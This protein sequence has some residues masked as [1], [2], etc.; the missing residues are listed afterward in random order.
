MQRCL[1]LALKGL[2]NVSSNPMVG[3]VI[4]HDNKIIGEGFHQKYG[5][6]HAEVNAI[7]SVKNKSLLSKSTLYVNLEPCSHFGKTPPCCNLII[8]KK[9]PNV[10]IGCLDTFSKVSGKGA[11][12]MKDANIKVDIGCLENKCR[13]LNK[14]FFTFHEKNRPY[15]ILKWAE[16]KDGYIAPNNQNKPFWMTSNKSKKLVH[17]WRTEED[18]ILVGRAT[19]EKDNPLL[20]SRE[21]KGNNPIRIVIDKSLK[22]SQNHNIFNSESKTIIF[23]EILSSDK[24]TNNY[25]KINFKKII[26]N[27]LEQ[28][29]SKNIQSVIIEG[30]TKTLQSFIDA[31]TWDEARIFTTK[32]EL[33][34]GVIAPNITGMVSEQKEID[35]DF[36]KILYNA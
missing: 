29:Y 25:I 8:E 33:I 31:N 30:G 18:A 15:I 2:G 28:L 34:Q 9:I 5:S 27:I 3:C 20:T 24:S 23:N 12:R 14:R 26:D 32:K 36:L 13:K 11:Q 1:T 19:V 21:K 6:P 10:V 35:V 7:D 16:S 4:V 17:K 22:L